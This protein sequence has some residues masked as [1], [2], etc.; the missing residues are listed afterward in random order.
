MFT[1]TKAALCLAACAAVAGVTSTARAAD[2]QQPQS[3]FQAQP[4]MLEDQTPGSESL[5]NEGLGRAGAGT[6]LK[7][8][9]IKAGG[10][11]EGSYTY[12]FS[13]PDG[14]HGI[15]EARAFDFEQD[16]GRMNQLALQL[17]RTP[18]VAAAAKAG[19]WDIGFGL[20]M[21]YGSD[22]RIIHANGLSGY[23][24]FS[25]PINQY[26]LTQAYLDIIAPFGNGI[27][28]RVGKFVTPIGYEVIAPIATVT[29]S[30][31]N[32]LFSHSFQFGFGI[33]FTQTG[34]TATYALNDKLSIMGGITRGWDQATNDNN[35][36]IDFLGQAKYTPNEAWT[37]YLNSSIGPQRA[38]NC[39]DYRYL[40]E[41]IAQYAPKNSKWSLAADATYAWEEHA[42]LSGGTAYWYGIAGY[43]TY[44]VNDYAAVNARGEWF[45]DDGGS[46]L[47]VN[48][49]FYE[50][51]LGLKLTPFP[52]DKIL[53]N[54]IIRPEVRGDFCS[55]DAFNG[56]KDD[57]QGTVAVDAIF[58]L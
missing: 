31:G 46:R 49:S 38:D 1:R 29:G 4:L 37:F 6:Y 42:S 21:M 8:W 32:A 28:I 3:Q 25:S 13:H 44:N 18:D 55:K 45:R 24:H 54:L 57:T 17:A 51:T 58:A 50:V 14:S 10:Y 36:A 19:K 26:D 35:G 20:D 22:G 11:I 47:G 39:S 52:H 27:D 5:L 43:A 30:S 16:A 15:N 12:N 9:G 53:S 40:F 41:G 56:G 7:D 34:I 48:A 33:P 2:P 23:N